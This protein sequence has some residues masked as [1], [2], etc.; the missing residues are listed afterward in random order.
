MVKVEQTA[1]RSDPAIEEYLADVDP[2]LLVVSPL[3]N[4]RS[5]QTDAIKSAKA[6]KI[7]TAVCVASWDHLTTKGL[8]RIH[9]DKVFV[10]NEIQ[11][12]EARELHDI[13]AS[14]VVVTGAQPF[15]K[16]FDRKP[17]R[18]R[19]AF[20]ARV[21]L[22]AGKPYVLFVGST[23]SISQP[24]LEVEFVRRWIAKLR[25]S[26]GPLKDIAVLVRPHPFNSTLWKDAE[27]E[28]RLA[29]VYP[30]NGANPVDEHDRE[31]Y[32]DS[33]F[34]SEA[35]LGINTSAMVEATILGRPVLSILDSEF[36]ATQEG[37]L[38]FR[39]LLPENGGFL[40]VARSLDE[41]VA[42]LEAVIADPAPYQ[43][44]VAD[45]VDRFV[46]PLG[47]DQNATERLVTGLEALADTAH[48][49]ATAQVADR[50]RRQDET[51]RKVARAVDG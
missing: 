21:G 51:S 37:T 7:S 14:D 49:R 26:N 27:L 44:R 1:L 43:R 15:D 12:K 31:D 6:L 3:V 34:H 13:P 46:R 35:V 41:H 23:A 2:D 11:K 30:R 5:W 45:F 40:E 39:H 8:I 10:W 20:L 4:V 36:E 17:S 32:F 38:H 25:A 24:R 19:E 16:W 48:S 47:R 18:T 22:P 50:A 9:P 42:Q 28:D 33:I 29:A